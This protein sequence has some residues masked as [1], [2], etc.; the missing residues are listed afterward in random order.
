MAT[1][2]PTHKDPISPQSEKF[3]KNF[4][5][6][7]VKNRLN[8][9]EGEDYLSE[10]DDMLGEAEFSIKKKIFS[11]P[12]METL[13][14]SDPKLSSV[15]DEMSSEGES[16]WGYHWN[17][18]VMNIIFNDYVLNSPKYIQKYKMA[19][20]KEK[21]RRDKS[22][23]N[24]L[25]KVGAEKMAQSGLA[26]QTNEIAENDKEITKVVFLIH[27]NN[28]DVFAYFPEENYD[29]GGKYR[30]GYAHIGQ[31]TAIDPNYARECR[32]ATPEEYQNLNAELEGIGYNF[33]VLN[34]IQESTSASSAGGAA[35][36]VGYEGPAAWS[37]KGDLMGGGKKKGQKIRK[38]IW[39]GGTIIQESEYLTDPSGFD[40]YVKTLNEESDANFVLNNSQAYGSID[41]M[42]PEN[43][44]VIRHD[45]ETGKMNNNSNIKDGIALQEKAK[46][47]SQQRF[48]GMVNAYKNN[49]LSA[50]DVGVDIERAANS[51]TDKEVDD[52]ARTKHKG[53][54]DHVDENNNFME[55]LKQIQPIPQGA[56]FREENGQQLLLYH[57][58][59]PEAKVWA[60]EV[61]KK[62]GITAHDT[63]TNNIKEDME[64]MIQNNGTSMSNKAQATGDMSNDTPMGT[65]ATG[66]LNE[67]DIKLLEEINNELKAFSIHHD[68]LKIMSE[69]RK[70]TS[71]ILNKRVN[72]ENPKNFKKDLQH[73][74]VKQVIDVE[75]ELEWKDQQ[76]DVKDPQKLGQDIEKK[77]IKVAD[78]TG[79]E[80]LKNVGDSTND[81]GDEIPKRNMTSDEQK[82]VNLYRNGL[83]SPIFDN[84]PDKRFEDRMKADMGDEI[85]DQ[86][87]KQIE[88]KGK[89]PMYNK[90]PQPIEDTTAKKVQFDKEQTGWN[91]RMGIDNKKSL[92]ESMV[93]GSY[94]NDIGDRH[95]IDF[96]L[97]EVKEL[98]IPSGTARQTGLFK[99]DFTG[100]GN[101]YNSKSIDNKVI[102][103][104]AV[105]NAMSSHQ[106]FT[107]GKEIF[108]MKNL[109]QSL[110]E[111]EI[112]EK[113]PVIN[114][115]MDKIKHLAGYKP[116]NYINT[117]NVKKNRG[118]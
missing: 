52:F 86:R 109:I 115:Q 113:K 117:K 1:I 43:Q 114:E 108:A 84:E 88:F 74:G 24:K 29:I 60:Q 85:Y 54:P 32:E 46:S 62:F 65:Q 26:K 17:E 61:S 41:N 63:N 45:I 77:E 93:T 59:N 118:F 13:V 70:T 111:N 49:E 98:K 75:K 103:N 3:E 42:N 14:F 78:M 22:G 73:S 56:D 16:R 28:P 91:E 15:Y 89:A 95:L 44:K 67:S 106:F 72:D 36:Y 116:N 105:V 58:G 39:K 40:K 23:I 38:P 81:D 4:K 55:I 33:E 79:D 27:P 94:H 18:T 104:E 66:G 97:S 96:N 48:M 21:K 82:E 50:D 5:K 19:I 100:L 69:E 37:T 30:S 10:I 34:G 2:K 57:S 64:T 99:L 9:R 102:V 92:K 76:T 6:T 87:N 31:H 47:K 8:I 112:K 68:K 12:K 53:L 110:N 90:D 83:H 11:L 7:M 80:A 25:K 35:G 107:N 20:P 71:Q 101:T 51:M